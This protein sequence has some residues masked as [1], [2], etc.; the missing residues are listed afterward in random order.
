MHAHCAPPLSLIREQSET[1][2]GYLRKTSCCDCGETKRK[3]RAPRRR[4][5]R[6]RDLLRFWTPTSTR[7]RS[8]AAGLHPAFSVQSTSYLYT[9][10]PNSR[11]LGML[12]AAEDR[13]GGIST[14]LDHPRSRGDTRAAGTARSMRGGAWRSARCSSAG[15]R[16]PLR[17]R[18]RLFLI[19]RLTPTP[20]PMPMPTRAERTRNPAHAMR[21]L[22]SRAMRSLSAAAACHPHADCLLPPAV[23]GPWVE[24]R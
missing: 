7:S 3:S 11:R 24:E 2:F 4:S 8:D 20:T 16:S 17:S 5:S 19:S 9:R 15:R 21:R 6:E 14:L 12:G 13:A 18:V 1:L 23:L 10:C 22:G